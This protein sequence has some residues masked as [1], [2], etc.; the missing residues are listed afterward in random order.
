MIVYTVSRQY[1]GVKH[2]PTSRAHCPQSN[3]LRQ[4][5]VLLLKKVLRAVDLSSQQH[6]MPIPPIMTPK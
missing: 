5:M 2:D 4:D 3:A 1:R 6:S